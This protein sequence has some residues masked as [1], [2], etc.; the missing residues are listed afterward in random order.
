MQVRQ[1]AGDKKRFTVSTRGLGDVKLTGLYTL[2]KN[3]NSS[4]LLNFGISIPTGETNAKDVM[5]MMNGSHTHSTLG[6]G[7]Q[8]GS[9][10]YDPIL[11][12]G[13]R[14]KWNKFSLG[15]QASGIWRLYQNA[16]DYHLGDEYQGSF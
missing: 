15:W 13:Y 6:Y 5:V 14:K 10:T 2:K 11:K 12:I 1:R 16:D 4:W 3:I 8:L 7:M 9:G